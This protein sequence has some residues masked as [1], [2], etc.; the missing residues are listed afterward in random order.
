VVRELSNEE[1]RSVVPTIV[2]AS[3]REAGFSAGW[4]D[5][6]TMLVEGGL[7]VRVARSDLLAPSLLDGVGAEVWE[8]PWGRNVVGNAASA[9]M[10]AGRCIECHA[11]MFHA[12]DELAASL[13]LAALSALPHM[14]L[15][16][17]PASGASTRRGR[18]GDYALRSWIR[19]NP[20]RSYALIVD[21]HAAARSRALG[22]D[23][24]NEIELL[25]GLGDD[26]ASGTAPRAQ[27]TTGW[28]RPIRVERVLRAY[29]RVLSG[30]GESV[31]LGADGSIVRETGFDRRR[32]ELL[33]GTRRPR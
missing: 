23:S 16:L 11:A 12:H 15:L 29:D 32:R 26:A 14:Q 3:S 4:E 24:A 18:I 2:L 21:E 5:V 7:G 8:L 30:E 20:E 22:F 13:G 6:V 28:D 1:S 19:R 25:G 17:S 31:R 27:L 10:L 33:T 9:V